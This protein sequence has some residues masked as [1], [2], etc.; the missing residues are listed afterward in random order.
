M[1]LST[2]P[3]RGRALA[4]LGA[5]LA[6]TVLLV[7]IGWSAWAQFERHEIRPTFP[8]VTAAVFAAG[9]AEVEVGLTYPSRVESD[10]LV[11][12]HDAGVTDPAGDLAAMDAHVAALE[13]QTGR[14]LRAKVLWVRGPAIGR[15]GQAWVGLALGSSTS[16]AGTLD[17]H[18]LAH[19]VLNQ[20]HRADAQ[21][22]M[23]LVEG[24]AEYQSQDRLTLTRNAR[25]MR[26]WVSLA[27]G[28]DERDPSRLANVEEDADSAAQLLVAHD[29]WAAED[30]LVRNLMEGAW[31][32]RDY[33]AVYWVGGA[34]VAYLIEA[35]GVGKFL[36]L[37]DRS[38]PGNVVPLTREVYGVDLATLEAAF[39]DD[40][41]ARL[42]ESGTDDRP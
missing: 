22:P 16:P 39:W 17:R 28:E 3:R 5:G 24:W 29:G 42:V 10:R 21:P 13:E 15:Q 27:T 31:Y 38:R 26:F 14:R 37:Y 35:H 41:E 20:H 36:D 8:L 6:P 19:A 23:L 25:D 2:G 12:V 34:W 11:M 40:V 30:C 32:A 7:L 33:G 18:E 9:V 1:R 4:L